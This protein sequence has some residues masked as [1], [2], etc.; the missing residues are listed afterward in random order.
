[1]PGYPLVISKDSQKKVLERLKAI[2]SEFKVWETQRRRYELIDRE[3]QRELTP[4]EHAKLIELIQKGEKLKDIKIPIMQPHIDSLVAQL[5]EIFLTGYPI[6]SA[7]A[8]PENI[9]VA[10]QI[11]A[12]NA[13]HQQRYGWVDNLLIWL[14]DGVKYN[15]NAAE[16]DWKRSTNYVFDSAASARANKPIR[17]K[18]EVSGNCIKRIDPY[19][20]IYDTT[21][22]PSQVHLGGEYCGYVE[23][24]NKIQFKMLVEQLDRSSVM[25]F[26]AAAESKPADQL[27]HR[28]SINN[29]VNLA[30]LA[31][32]QFNWFKFAGIDESNS[33]NIRFSGDYEI[34]TMYMRV[35]PKDYAI[36]VPM[37]TNVQIWKFIIV[38]NCQIL[39]SEMQT[40]YN[41]S[42]P[43]VIS[44][45]RNDGLTQQTKT[46]AELIEPIQ[47]YTTT[48][49]NARTSSLRRAVNDRA[50]YD[51]SR[52]EPRYVNS[53]NP[54]AKIPVKPSAFGKPMSDAYM[55]I[56]YRDDTAG[57]LTGDLLYV[58]AQAEEITGSN[59]AARGNF[60]KGNK[61]RT[62]FV[63]IMGNSA[64]RVMLLAQSIH[65]QA[66]SWIKNMVRDNILQYQPNMTI[67]DPTTGRRRDV[68][69][70]V[71][72]S[73]GF[74]FKM[75]DGMQPLEKINDPQS[76]LL[77]YQEVKGDPQL[78]ANYNMPALSSYI[79]KMLGANEVARFQVSQPQAQANAAAQAQ[80]AATNAAAESAGSAAGQ[81]AVTGVPQ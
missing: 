72:R 80:A 24:M 68:D 32:T 23:R 74:E 70:N 31:G 14:M 9:D 49:H 12:L 3:Y 15:I 47:S 42:F 1:M 33:S 13:I 39:Y 18:T 11:D 2:T 19:N 25:N 10:T 54:T 37:N 26:R 22:A 53:P 75:A 59:K 17:V 8:D 67:A 5:S 29:F 20:L 69:P 64:S 71:L 6:I 77:A 43:L 41:E 35:V 28:P 21:V 60:V 76:L 63:D 40:N 27:Y 7:A 56:P 51:P 38:N 48:L 66:F 45:P 79:F 58:T 81:A 61:T 50:L 16:V 78:R 34:L 65:S 36:S 52:I 55:P 57:L 46:M 62:E 73:Y 44:Q 30:E 4:E